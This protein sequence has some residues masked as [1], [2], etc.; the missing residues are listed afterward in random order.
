MAN[1]V[2]SDQ[3]PHSV[4]SLICAGYNAVFF[5]F[6][7]FYYLIDLNIY[8]IVTKTIFRHIYVFGCF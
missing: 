8:K 3:M 1:G 4:V 7:F 2:D 5:F 6:L